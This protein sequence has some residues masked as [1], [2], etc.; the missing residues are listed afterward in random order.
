[1]VKDIEKGKIIGVIHALPKIFSD[2]I[3]NKKGDIFLKYV[4][5]QPTK[6]SKIKLQEGMKLYIYESKS[7]NI[8]GEAII[9][10]ID[11]LTYKDILNKSYKRLML[12]NKELEVYCGERTGRKAMLLFLNKVKKYTS[13]IKIT[14][15]VT[16]GGLYVTKDNI[17]QLK[18]R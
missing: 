2:R 12:T 17:N 1:M 9:Q 16:M 18:L 13:P 3:L 6:K 14:R 5:F 7:S 4:S 10:N 11:F 8:V 15:K